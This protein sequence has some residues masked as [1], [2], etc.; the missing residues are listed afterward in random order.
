MKKLQGKVIL[1]AGGGGLGNGLAR[2]YAQDGASVV[3][4]HNHLDAAQAVANEVEAAG[5]TMSAV[6]LD[7]T[8]EATIVAAVAM[9]TEKYG[10]LDGLHANFAVLSKAKDDTDVINTPLDVVDITMRV[11]LIGYFLCTRHALPAIIARGGGAIVYTSSIGA[12]TAEHT[13]VAYAMSKAAGHALMRHVAGKY[14]AQG[15][16]ANSITPGLIKT[17]KWAALPEATV[18]YLEKMALDRAAIKSGVVTP[19][20]IAALGSLLMSDD[21]K[22]ITGQVLS[23]DGGMTM[24]P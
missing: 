5:G 6:H 15:V 20:H 12:H 23:V 14:G 4:G 22:F 2:R 10:G 3:L 1:V 13:Q 7:G 24:R 8:D 21:G 16:R 18:A 19:D 9:A 17:E 11:N